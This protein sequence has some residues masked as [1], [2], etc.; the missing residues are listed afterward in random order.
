MLAFR[1]HEDFIASYLHRQPDF[2]F[3]GLG[4]MT[5]LRTYSRLKEDGT[6]ESWYETVRRVV[7][8]AY[9]IQKQ[10]IE[11]NELGWNES[12][13][14]RSAQEMYERIFT[15]KFLPPGRMLWALGTPVVHEKK[16]DRHYLI[17]HL[18]LQNI[19]ATR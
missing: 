7:E 8:G 5:Y 10:H 3:N 4:M 6:K 15:M 13:A 16:S 19:S 9:S 11:Q 12:K 1:L 14:Q 2:G 17:V 18:S